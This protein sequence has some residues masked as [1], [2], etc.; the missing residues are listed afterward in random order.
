MKLQ[1]ALGSLLRSIKYS[2]PENLQLLIH[3]I[4]H[5]SP[6]Q[7]VVK[8]FRENMQGLLRAG[9]V[10]RDEVVSGEEVIAVALE[11]IP[12]R[13]SWPEC[14]ASG[15][16][17]ASSTSNQYG[18]PSYLHEPTDAAINVGLG[19]T[20][21]EPSQAIFDD[22]FLSRAMGSSLQVESA[23]IEACEPPIN[24]QYDY[25]P[26]FSDSWCLSQADS[27]YN[28]TAAPN[29]AAITPIP[30]LTRYG[31]DADVTW[32]LTLS[33]HEGQHSPLGAMS[34]FP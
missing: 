20:L 32:S 3:T 14:L 10:G 28:P 18:S 4:R 16:A 12:Q 22:M 15:G 1:N 2:S 33:E 21:Y 9:Y 23:P 29:D 6:I 5:D 11:Q 25:W 13:R 26:S 27:M 24:I 19:G 8:A 34:N 31:A 17:S 30:P 7:E